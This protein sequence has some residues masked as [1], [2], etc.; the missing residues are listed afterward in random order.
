M[1]S[2]TPEDA[3][4]NAADL[5]AAAD[6]VEGPRPQKRWKAG[7]VLKMDDGSYYVITTKQQS[8]PP[9]VLDR[10]CDGSA[11]DDFINGDRSLRL[12]RVVPGPTDEDLAEG[13]AD[14]AEALREMGMR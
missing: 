3:R 12:M 10:H 6:E 9:R 8:D 13:E 7:D 14:A 4:S 2:L 1:M 5:I 11:F